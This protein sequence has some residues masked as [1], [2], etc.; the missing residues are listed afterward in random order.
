MNTIDYKAQDAFVKENKTQ[1]DAI[2]RRFAAAD[3]SLS[4]TELAQAY[5]AAPFAGFKPLA[6]LVNTANQL[7]RIRDYRVAYFMYR[8]ALAA[9]PLSML[10]LKKAANCSFFAV[11]DADATAQLRAQVKML[12]EVILASGDGAT[13]A[14]AYRVVRTSDAYQLLWDVV[15]VKDVISCNVVATE[16]GESVDE[17]LVQVRDEK[18]P[19]SIYVACYGETDADRADFFQRK[20]GF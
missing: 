19:R 17:L 14:T 20:K 9:D 4:A 1:F 10:V 3:T 16:N 8:D 5:Y 11:I 15:G 13:P 12:Q 2:L 7:Y 6:D 18:E